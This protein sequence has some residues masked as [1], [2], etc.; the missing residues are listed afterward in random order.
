M[1]VA[2]VGASGRMG[3]AVVRLAVGAGMELACA[4]GASDVGCDAGELAGVGTVGTPVVDGLAALERTKADVVIDFSAPDVTLALAPIAAAARIAIVSG[5]TGLSDA[6]RKALD[7]AAARVP[8]LWEPNMSLGVFLL[9]KLVAQ[10]VSALAEW[11]IEVVET[12]HRAKVDARRRRY[13]CFAWPRSRSAAPRRGAPG[14]RASGH[15]GC[16]HE[17][18]DRDARAA[19]RRRGGRPTRCT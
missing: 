18:G 17:R 6:G 5:T 12:H 3:R 19:R 1:R 9:S 7:E 4:I 10:A 14:A 2:V 11:D 15:A 16:A 13:G 8:V